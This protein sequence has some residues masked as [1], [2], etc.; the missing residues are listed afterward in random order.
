MAITGLIQNHNHDDRYIQK[1][2]QNKVWQRWQGNSASAI[3]VN[4]PQY[5]MC[6][7]YVMHNGSSAYTQWIQFP[8]EFCNGTNHTLLQTTSYGAGERDNVTTTYHG[9][10]L[11]YNGTTLTVKPNGSIRILKIYSTW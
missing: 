4:I 10:S 5:Q 3:N 7:V 9:I 2:E 8:V 11:T 6:Y 1:S